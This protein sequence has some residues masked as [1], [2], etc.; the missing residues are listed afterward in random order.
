M[1]NWP[2]WPRGVVSKD[3]RVKEDSVQYRCAQGVDGENEIEKT[4]DEDDRR[5]QPGG[6]CASERLDLRSRGRASGT[7]RTRRY[8]CGDVRSP[9]PKVLVSPESADNPRRDMGGVLHTLSLAC[10]NIYPQHKRTTYAL[11]PRKP[12]LNSRHDKDCYE[13]LAEEE[14]RPQRAATI[15]SVPRQLPTSDS[16]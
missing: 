4:N 7:V 14:G 2:R 1:S 9:V 15:V 8:S 16:L 5:S 6:K 10:G 11:R 12:S 3:G 13:R